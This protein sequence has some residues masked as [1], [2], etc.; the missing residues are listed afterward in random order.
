MV[1]LL[2]LIIRIG[3]LFGG[4]RRRLDSRSVQAWARTRAAGIRTSVSFSFSHL[5]GANGRR[6]TTQ[7]PPEIHEIR[8][9]PGMPWSNVAR[10]ALFV[11]ASLS[12]CPS[13]TCRG[14]QT[15]AGNS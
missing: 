12:R 9:A 13:V 2:T 14:D 11:S 5:K 10:I 8:W 15:Q 3:F 6:E 7:L 1:T 4:P